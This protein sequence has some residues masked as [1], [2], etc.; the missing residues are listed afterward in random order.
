M[1]DYS[2]LVKADRG[3]D[4]IDIHL[5]NADGFEDFAKRLN[6][7]Q[8]AALA[9]QKFEGRGYQ[10]GIVPDG[11]GWFAVGGVADPGELS[12]WCLAKL[13]EDLPEG[14]YRLAGTAAENGPGPAVFGWLTAQYRFDRYL[15]DDKPTGPRILLSGQAGR[16]EPLVAEAEAEMLVRDLV[17]TCLLYTSPSPRDRQKSRMP[18]SA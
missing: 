17:N 7:S 8:R 2:D 14:T 11:D 13:A 1:T 16:I 10:V 9:G 4:A 3:Q 5:V 6:A 12:S 18:S 15:Q